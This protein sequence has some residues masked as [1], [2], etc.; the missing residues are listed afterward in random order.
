VSRAQLK[1]PPVR[2]DRDHYDLLRAQ[3]LR[4]DGWRCQS[5]GSMSNL[6]VHHKTFRSRCG[7]DCE[8]NL[9]S[10]CGLCRA[11]PAPWLRHSLA[12]SKIGGHCPRSEALVSNRGWSKPSERTTCINNC[13]PARRFHLTIAA[14]SFCSFP[15]PILVVDPCVRLFQTGS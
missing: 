4:R 6:E 12:F 2:L 15:G 13:G 11:P 14:P 8:E 9:I 7:N 5:Y 10:L 1:S 3:V